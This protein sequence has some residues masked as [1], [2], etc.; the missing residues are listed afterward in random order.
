MQK[1]FLLSTCAL[2]LYACPQQQKKAPSKN[3]SQ[4]QH[5]DYGNQIS[6]MRE[7]LSQALSKINSLQTKIGHGSVNQKDTETLEKLKKELENLQDKVSGITSDSATVKQLQTKIAKLEDKIKKLEGKESDEDEATD[8]AEAEDDGELP[9][10]QV[11]LDKVEKDKQENITLV[12]GGIEK[13]EGSEVKAGTYV[14]FYSNK[15]VVIEKIEYG[16]L[17]LSAK[18]NDKGGEQQHVSEF[19]ISVS[20]KH[21]GKETCVSATL[22]LLAQL[23]RSEKILMEQGKGAC[24]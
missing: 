3:E 12:K 18:I 6:S 5:V 23:D 10:I 7:Q 2:L 22:D 20:F 13:Q 21:Q 11:A 16:K 17:S 9:V 19:P 1:F 14:T 8:E 4:D 24:Q 15:D